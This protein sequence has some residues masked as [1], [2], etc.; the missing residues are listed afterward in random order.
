MWWQTWHP[1]N[2][3]SCT[4]LCEATILYLR[5]ARFT[6]LWAS[7]PFIKVCHSWRTSFG[8]G[9]FS[10]LC[11]KKVFF[12]TINRDFLLLL[13][14]IFDWKF[15]FSTL[16][17]RVLVLGYITVVS[18]IFVEFVSWVIFDNKMFYSPHLLFFSF[19]W[20][21]RVMLSGLNQAKYKDWYDH[22]VNWRL[23]YR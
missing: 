21:I 22:N 14:P 2:E 16:I 9:D 7:V 19:I 15:I 5:E 11:P 12:S 18:S 3:V 4:E 20:L 8:S 10:P 6:P 1:A 23:F 17:S 13:K